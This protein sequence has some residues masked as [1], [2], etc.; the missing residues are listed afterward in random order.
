MITRVLA[1]ATAALVVASE[2][3]SAW[4]L[5]WADG[6]KTLKVAEA[7]CCTLVVSTDSLQATLP[8]EWRL[9]WACDAGVAPLRWT[10]EDCGFQLAAACVLS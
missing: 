2:G 4:S 6:S 9:V 8:S 1:I 10:G 5:K 3:A 7:R